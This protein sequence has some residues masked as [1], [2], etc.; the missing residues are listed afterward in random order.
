MKVSKSVNVAFATIFYLVSTAIA[1]DS[2]NYAAYAP[3]ATFT[4]A[5]E[6]GFFS[7]HNISVMFHQI[8]SE[9]STHSESLFSRYDV[10][11]VTM[12]EALDITL[13]HELPIF[14]LGQMD[15]GPE[16][17]FAAS[18]GVESFNEM[19]GQTVLIDGHETGYAYATQIIMEHN[20]L[21]DSDYVT[22]VRICDQPQ[23]VI[24]LMVSGRPRNCRSLLTS[25]VYERNLCYDPLVPIYIPSRF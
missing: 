11:S 8:A 22:K 7:H 19:R 6:L 16:L 18:A 10:M 17:V 5:Q 23:V 21:T 15:A 9:V 12:D 14:V 2:I 13:N 1:I 24:W 4:V 3:S 20:G 25:Y